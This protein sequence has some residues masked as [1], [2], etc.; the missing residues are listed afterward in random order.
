MNNKIILACAKTP[1]LKRAGIKNSE[2]ELHE[3]NREQ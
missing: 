2:T 3:L 1:F